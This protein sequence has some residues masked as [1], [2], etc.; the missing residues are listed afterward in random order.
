[1][2]DK[3]VKTP[4]KD[5]DL[6]ASDAEISALVKGQPTATAQL[7]DAAVVTDADRER[8]RLEN[9][10]H[11]RKLRR[12]RALELAVQARAASRDP[13]GNVLV[14]AE[15]LLAWLEGKPASELGTAS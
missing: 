11:E 4:G 10:E 2:S 1:M 8:W 6:P 7:S 13:R 12:L 9:E 5:A 3:D 14:E 15:R